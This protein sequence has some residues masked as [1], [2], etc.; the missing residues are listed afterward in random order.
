[1]TH[2]N[3]LHF[4]CLVSTIACISVISAKAQDTTAFTP[5]AL[6]TIYV[7]G[8][9]NGGV[10][11][12]NYDRLLD[13][14][15][16]VRIGVSY[17]EGRGTE[18]FSSSMALPLSVSYLINFPTSPSHIELG[19]GLTPYRSYFLYYET[20]SEFVN[21]FLIF[22][23]MLGYRFQPQEGGF[24]FRILATPSFV[25]FE[26]KPILITTPIWGGISV[27]YTF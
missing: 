15:W 17:F 26:K 3:I 21:Q 4:L 14:H 7:E 25:L 18:T 2:K 10:Y 9:G 19:I 6:N 23:P 24:N 20:L 1:M 12:L 11:S 5:K 16:A 22:T 27:G 8:L 13:S